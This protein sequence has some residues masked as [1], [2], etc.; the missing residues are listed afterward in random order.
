[1]HGTEIAHTF[2]D[3]SVLQLETRYAEL[4]V[5]LAQLNKQ[6]S[7]E[8][9]LDKAQALR[10]QAS[11]LRTKLANFKREIGRERQNFTDIARGRKVA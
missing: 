11:E 5:E 7:T 10:D 2:G 1:M 8:E 4:E 3:P 6:I 9:D